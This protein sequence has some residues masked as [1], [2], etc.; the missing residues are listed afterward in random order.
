MASFAR[1]RPSTEPGPIVASLFEI[2]KYAN[3]MGADAIQIY[4]NIYWLNFFPVLLHCPAEDL[5]TPW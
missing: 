4:N 2:K 3:N 5:S 1:P